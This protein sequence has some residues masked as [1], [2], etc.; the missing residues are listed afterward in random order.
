MIE[1]LADVPPGTLIPAE[2]GVFEVAEL[3]HWIA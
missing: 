3:E 2:A 1:R